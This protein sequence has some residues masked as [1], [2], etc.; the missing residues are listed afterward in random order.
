MVQIS[1]PKVKWEKMGTWRV[2]DDQPDPPTNDDYG[3][4]KGWKMVESLI[5][6]KGGGSFIIPTDQIMLVHTHKHSH[7]FII[8]C[9]IPFMLFNH[10]IHTRLIYNTPTGVG[11]GVR[12]TEDARLSA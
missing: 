7:S 3:P 5:V 10:H 1:G 4:V 8:V 6:A 11:E 9:T 12:T 2:I